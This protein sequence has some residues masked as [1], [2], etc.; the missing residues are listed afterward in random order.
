MYDILYFSKRNFLSVLS[1]AGQGTLANSV[2][3][4]LSRR[5]SIAKRSA[6]TAIR[7]EGRI[8]FSVN[9]ITPPS[10]VEAERSLTADLTITVRLAPYI[11]LDPV[12]IFN[13]PNARI[14]ERIANS[15]E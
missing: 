7:L 11:V 13:A 4:S 1:H 6:C 8:S 3:R 14:A 9:A 12:A 15:V 10:S 2:M 5:I